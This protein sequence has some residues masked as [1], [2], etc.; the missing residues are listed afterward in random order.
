MSTCDTPQKDTEL[1]EEKT[2][3]KEILKDMTID[4]RPEANS[5]NNQ[6]EI[7]YLLSCNWFKQWKLKVGF[8]DEDELT[9]TNDTAETDKMKFELPKLNEDLIDFEYMDATPNLIHQ[10]DVQFSIINYPVKEG[11]LEEREFIYINKQLW[12]YFNEKYPNGYA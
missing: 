2:Q 10:K 12:D 1:F 4:I 3:V 8:D 7:I 6:R 9:S 11:I 5:E